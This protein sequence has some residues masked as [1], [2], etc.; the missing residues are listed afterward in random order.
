M[1]TTWTCASGHTHDA[2]KLL[3]GLEP[4]ATPGAE[5]KASG[6]RLDAVDYGAGPSTITPKGRFNAA[7][8]GRTKF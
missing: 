5:C 6:D 4:D 3:R 2:A 1:A 8:R 7:D